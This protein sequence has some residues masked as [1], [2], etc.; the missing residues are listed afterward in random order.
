[1]FMQFYPR[2]DFEAAQPGLPAGMVNILIHGTEIRPRECLLDCMP[3]ETG[4]AGLFSAG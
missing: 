2:L 4:A 3:A 1:M